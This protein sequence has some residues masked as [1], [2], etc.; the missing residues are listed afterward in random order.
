MTYSTRVLFVLGA[1]VALEIFEFFAIHREATNVFGLK[2]GWRI[3]FYCFV[4]FSVAGSLAALTGL[5]HDARNLPWWAALLLLVFAI[6]YRPQLIAANS[7]GLAGYRF[8]G[9]HRR[10]LPW[11]EVFIVTSNWQVENVRFW[12]FTGYEIAVT[13]R[14]GTRI[15]HTI[16]LRKRPEFLDELRKYLPR[17]VFSP[18]LYDWHP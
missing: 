15:S 3:Y 8:W 2:L 16:F 9:I 14:N 1:V 18:G 6:F 13:G 17:V 7:Q 4:V 11:S 12:R 10:F 5:S